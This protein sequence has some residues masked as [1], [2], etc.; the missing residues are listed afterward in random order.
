[1]NKTLRIIQLINLLN[2]RRSVT[3]K[4]IREVCSI[5]ERTAYRY[6]NTIS[7]ANIPVYFDKSIQAYR[8]NTD[9]NLAINDL[10]FGESVLAVVALKALAAVAGD[11]YRHDIEQL[12]TK[13]LVRQDSEV[14]AV[15]GPATERLTSA[16]E[17]MDVSGDLSAALIHV[18]VCCGREVRI[19]YGDHSGT[20]QGLDIN[21]PRLIF[22]G[23]WRLGEKGEPGSSA[24][25]MS[26]IDKVEIA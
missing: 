16:L 18:A 15:L 21:H 2:T 22:K 11:G 14:E 12:I 3:V 7:E 25:N 23:G 10:S 19:V 13:V 4:T 8:L 26:G 24:R 5:P 17:G 1:M 6:L 20:K 9:V